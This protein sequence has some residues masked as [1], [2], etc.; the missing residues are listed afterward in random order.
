MLHACVTAVC[1]CCSQGRPR[2]VWRALRVF[3]CSHA[4]TLGLACRVKGHGERVACVTIHP[5]IT[6]ASRGPRDVA[7]FFLLRHLKGTYI[8]SI[9]VSLTFR[10]TSQHPS[11]TPHPPLLYTTAPPHPIPIPIEPYRCWCYISMTIVS[12]C[13]PLPVGCR[14]RKQ[15][16]GV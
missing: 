14:W 8:R 16:S 2:P 10:S 7:Y 13:L 5:R 9:P 4:V 3:L 15:S 6:G 1:C 11:P 12:A